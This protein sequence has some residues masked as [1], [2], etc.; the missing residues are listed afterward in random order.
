[1]AMKTVQLN[2]YT[3]AM[4]NC[5]AQLQ[6]EEDLQRAAKTSGQFLTNMIQGR[7]MQ[8]L[9]TLVCH[10][11][12][13][14]DKTLE[15]QLGMILMDLLSDKFFAVFRE[16]VRERPEIVFIIARRITEIEE[17]HGGNRGRIDALFRG[18]S[19][20]YFE[21]RNFKLIM[22]WIVTN[23]EVEKVVFLSR[24]QQ[25]VKDTALLKT[26]EFIIQNDK[27]GITPAVFNR[28]LVKNKINRLND[29]VKS[30]DW[31]IEAAFVQEKMARL[32]NWRE[33][34]NRL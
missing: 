28:Y 27:V 29:L 1:M 14:T 31:K 18:I 11:H 5:L 30:G 33:Y 4:K 19:R 8:Y 22:R 7:F 23:P 2:P 13:I 25:R 12:Q 17:H 3:Q 32:I 16:K 21:Y 24:I 10:T 20:H 9:V 26:L 34:M 6:D 15:K